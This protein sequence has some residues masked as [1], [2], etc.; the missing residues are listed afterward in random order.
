V[1][2]FS[3]AVGSGVGVDFHKSGGHL[4]AC[5]DLVPRFAMQVPEFVQ[6]DWAL[7]MVQVG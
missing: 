4:H 2:N 7:V 1:G 3:E 6:L 5:S